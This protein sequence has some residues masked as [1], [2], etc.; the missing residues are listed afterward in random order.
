MEL[1]QLEDHFVDIG[2]Q[3]LTSSFDMREQ[4]QT[5]KAFIFDW[6]GVFNDGRK[7]SNT[8]SDFTEVDSMG[9]NMMRYGY[10]RNA[11]QMPKVAVITGENNPSA[12]QWAKREHLDAVYMNAKDKSLALIHF[13]EKHGLK[14]KEVAFFYDDILDIPIAEKAGLRF[15]VGR[16]ANPL[17]L[18]YVEN[19]HLADYISAAQGNEHAVREFSE[20]V[21]GLLD[22]HFEVISSRAKYD[23]DYESFIKQRQQ[24]QSQFYLFNGSDFEQVND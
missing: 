16:L 9:T 2:G 18:K 23:S 20:M 10:F 11:K 5:I 14:P 12:R 22:Q 15:C 13:C 21:L 3:F 4:M 6:D 19:H 7:G 24:N 17:F 1:A 8:N